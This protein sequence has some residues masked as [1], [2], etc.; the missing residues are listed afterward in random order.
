MVLEAEDK[1][2]LQNF[3]ASLRPYQITQLNYATLSNAQKAYVRIYVISLARQAFR[4]TWLATGAKPDIDGWLANNKD[5][6][7]MDKRTLLRAALEA[8][9]AEEQYLHN[10]FFNG[11]DTQCN[12]IQ[13]DRF[14]AHTATENTWILS[15]YTLNKW[16]GWVGEAAGTFNAVINA[17][18]TAAVTATMIQALIPLVFGAYHYKSSSYWYHSTMRSSSWVYLFLYVNTNFNSK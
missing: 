6:Y 5:N 16:Y 9:I 15:N 13:I 17:A 4:A 10:Q 14:A 12:H 3:Q 11:E 1:K 8:E 2:A 7:P 18:I